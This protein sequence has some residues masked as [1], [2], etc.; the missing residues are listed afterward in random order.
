MSECS[1]GIEQGG[2]AGDYN[3][4]EQTPRRETPTLETD[5]QTALWMDCVANTACENLEKNP[6][7]ANPVM[8]LFVMWACTVTCEDVAAP[9][10]IV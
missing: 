9:I 1:L 2:P 8:I 7:R 4:N 10:A 5:Q 3:P 6:L